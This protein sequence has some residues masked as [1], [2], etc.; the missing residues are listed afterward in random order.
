MVRKKFEK[1]VWGAE[2][3][4]S[5][6]TEWKSMWL[7]PSVAALWSLTPECLGK[8]GGG[9]VQSIVNAR[10]RILELTQGIESYGMVNGERS[11]EQRT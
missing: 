7:P 1:G 4:I 6:G 2:R 5:N 9:R 11:N 10:Q 3:P 8:W